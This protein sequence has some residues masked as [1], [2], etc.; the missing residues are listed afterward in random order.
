MIFSGEIT[1]ISLRTWTRQQHEIS[2]STAPLVHP[3]IPRN[4]TNFLI[5]K[6]QTRHLEGQLDLAVVVALVP[7]HVL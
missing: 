3:H 5:I 6:R 1:I 2:Q 7:D 4:R